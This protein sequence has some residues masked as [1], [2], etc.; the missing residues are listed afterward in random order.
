LRLPLGWVDE[1]QP[2]GRY[3]AAVFLLHPGPS[4]LV[5]ATFVAIATL[6]TR[7]AP[8]P[9]R[10][11]QLVAI[12]LPIQ[13]CIGITNDL[14]DRARDAVAKPYKP[15]TGGAVNSRLA[16]VS[17]VLLA[18]L[19]LG[20]AATVN[21]TTLVLSAAGLAAGLAYDF[22]LH[23]TPVSFIPWWAGMAALPLAAYA[24]SGSLTARSALL[25]VGFSGLVAVSLHLANAA[26]DIDDDRA[27]G[28]A[29]LA[30]VLG[31]PWSRRLAVAGLA[32]TGVLAT[33][34]AFPLGQAGVW[35]LIADGVLLLALLAT[36]VVRPRRPFPML[37]VATAV[38]AV[39]WLATLPHV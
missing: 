21:A 25:I 16:L 35:L 13:F 7:A 6:A 12:M 22:G 11:F 28:S 18:A 1:R 20:V 37:A 23:R 9:L 36:T 2:G 19:G 15:L 3:K 38:F 29:S 27:S 31:P 24:A 30:V 17:A 33:A 10:A 39:G 5:T 26:P 34:T 14:A 4:L 8:P 32:A